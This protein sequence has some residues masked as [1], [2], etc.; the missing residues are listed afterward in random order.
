YASR[1][2]LPELQRVAGIGQVTLFGT[3]R[4]MRIWVDPAKLVSYGLSL[5]DVNAAIRAQNGLVPAGALGDR[6]NVIDQTMTATV[7]V[8]G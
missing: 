5:S 3:E 4:A 7:V 6:P 8:N 1:N 2:V